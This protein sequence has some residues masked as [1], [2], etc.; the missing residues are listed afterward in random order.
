MNISTSGELR[1]GALTS[2]SVTSVKFSELEF[3][4]SFVS[5]APE[6]ASR[7][8]LSIATGDIYY[9][10]MDEKPEELPDD[11]DEPGRYLDIP[12]KNA[13]DLGRRL[14]ED[15]VSARM[16]EDFSLVLEMFRS[17]GAYA[18]F[19]SYLRFHGLLEDWREYEERRSESAL[20]SWCAENGLRV[21]D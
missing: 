19:K 2:E 8:L 12:H 7:A 1:P 17:R 13:F 4:F 10:P 14:V 6:C 3:A 11:I 15:Y 20:R 16:P 18:R 21:I 5:E 9:I